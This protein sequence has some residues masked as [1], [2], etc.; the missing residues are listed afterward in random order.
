MKSSNTPITIVICAGSLATS[1]FADP[2]SGYAQTTLITNATDPD[3]VN[4]GGISSSTSS[5]FWVS[6]NG[7]GKA[8]LYNGAG[9]KQGLVITMPAGSTAIIGMHQSGA[10]EFINSAETEIRRKN[11]NPVG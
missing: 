7:S 8:T 10:G 3:L 9:V 5:P 6:D 11:G 1:L 4:P 2:L